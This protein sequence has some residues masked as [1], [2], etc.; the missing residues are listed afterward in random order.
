MTKKKFEVKN[1]KNKI[2]SL[3]GHYCDI[4]IH[5]NEKTERCDLADPDTCW[6]YKIMCNLMQ[7]E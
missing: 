6:V 2:A 3:K 1:F 5:F 7:S 4:C